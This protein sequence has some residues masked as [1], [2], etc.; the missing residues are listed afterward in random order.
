MS[1]CWMCLKQERKIKTVN[2]RIPGS[3]CEGVDLCLYCETAVALV[4]QDISRRY[5]RRMLDGLETEKKDLTR[6]TEGDIFRA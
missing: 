4:I 5:R 1:L 6:C 3:P 2:L